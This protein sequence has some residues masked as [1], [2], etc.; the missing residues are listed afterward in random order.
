SS[1]TTPGAPS[2]SALLSLLATSLASPRW[3][4][5]QSQ[6]SSSCSPFSLPPST[7][8]APSKPSPALASASASLSAF[9][10]PDPS[11]APRSIL[12]AP[13]APLSLL[14]T[15]PATA[16]TGSALLPAASSPASFTTPCT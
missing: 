16:S 12:L 10:S 1:P 4:S 13:S 8:A 9:S 11:P 14:P 6:P 7:S 3:P 15:G 2:L 5:R